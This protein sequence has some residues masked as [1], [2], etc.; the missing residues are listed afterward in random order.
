MGPMPGM[1]MENMGPMPGQEN[2]GPMPGQENMGPMEGEQEQGGGGGVMWNGIFY[3]PGQEAALNLAMMNFP[4]GGQNGGMGEGG[5]GGSP[6]GPGLGGGTNILNATPAKDTLIGT[7]GQQDTFIFTLSEIAGYGSPFN[8]SNLETNAANAD[9]LLNFNSADGDKIRIDDSGSPMSVAAI[10]TGF[11][12]INPNPGEYALYQN[13]TSG[14]VFVTN[15]TDLSSFDP[16]DFTDV[17]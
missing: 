3:P 4:N 8:A 5:G 15:D 13:A 12:I 6:P 17:V 11:S 1:G 2:M 7:D 9:T 14:I 10:G 16:A